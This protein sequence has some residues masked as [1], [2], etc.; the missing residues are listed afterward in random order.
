[1]VIAAGIVSCRSEPE[2]REPA[3]G[4]GVGRRAN[5]AAERSPDPPD[6]QEDGVVTENE[7]VVREFIEAWSRLDPE[8]L[9]AYFCD[10]GVYHNMPMQ[11]VA[12]RQNIE[13]MIRGFTASWTETRWEILHLVAQGD[14][15]IAERVDRTK[16][17]DKA[18]DLPCTGVF[19]MQDGKI[20]VWRDYFDLATYTNGMS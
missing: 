6:R 9:A 17:G 2:G 4:A 15:V 5:A 20:R 11:A 19:E 16:A 3:P 7:R 12:G 8:E 14:V 18:V 10:D 1:V 13:Q